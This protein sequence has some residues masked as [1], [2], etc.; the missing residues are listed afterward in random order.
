MA[1]CNL[2]IIMMAFLNRDAWLP[3]GLFSSEL[4]LTVP[5]VVFCKTAIRGLVRYSHHSCGCYLRSRLFLAVT[6]EMG[7]FRVVVGEVGDGGIIDD[8]SDEFIGI[9]LHLK[10]DH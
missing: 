9:L 6:G 5:L 1:V 4:A 8:L 7:N 3:A 2:R 10:T